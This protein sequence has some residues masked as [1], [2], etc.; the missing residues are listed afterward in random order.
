MEQASEAA[1]QARRTKEKGAT[2]IKSEKKKNK[3]KIKT[4]KKRTKKGGSSNEGS[5]REL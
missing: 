5:E 2:S 1:A 4:K 3:T